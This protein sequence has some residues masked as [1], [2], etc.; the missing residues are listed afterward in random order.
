MPPTHASPRHPAPPDELDGRRAAILDAVVAEYVATAQPVGSATVARAPKV[1]VS[2]ATVRAEMVALERE[3][4][5]TQPHTSAGRV[6]TDR[7]YRFFVDHLAEPG[8]L[9]PI[10]RTRVSSFFD[11]LRGEM[12]EVLERT[13]S[14]L[15]ELT[16]HAAVVVGPMHGTA[17]ILSVQV[18]ALARCVVL[19]VVVLDD[20]AVEKATIELD[21][22]VEPSTLEAVSASM[23]ARLEGVALKQVAMAEPLAGPKGVARIVARLEEAVAAMAA[24]REP[25]QVFIGGSSRLA[26]SFDAVDTV[27][28]VLQ[29]LEQQLVVVDL[30]NDVLQRG[31]SVAIGEEH[32]YE[33]LSS[34]ALVV[35]PI[36][37]EGSPGGVVGILGPTRM[38][39]P[40]AI[41][42]ADAVS[43]QLGHR[44]ESARHGEGE[45]EHPHRG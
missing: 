44:L 21:E 28:N 22:D 35:A 41:A 15:A 37:I 8:I 24:R 30:L 4:Y 12:E 6:P 29:I 1:A 23:R 45:H 19:V 34:C 13:S 26:A 2:P 14:M 16:S 40:S 10:E 7:G 9:G 5:L 11:H 36:S 39:Y 43:T 25:E 32:G 31:L 27:R 3:G 42:A 33:P 20:G 17:T 18:V 38:N